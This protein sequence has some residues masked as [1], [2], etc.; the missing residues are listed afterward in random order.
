VKLYCSSAKAM[1]QQ[2]QQN[3]T[4]NEGLQRR[5]VTSRRQD[6]GSNLD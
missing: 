6:S 2:Q 5:A 3:I 4:E 1:Q